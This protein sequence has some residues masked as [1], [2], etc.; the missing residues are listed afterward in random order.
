MSQTE[1]AVTPSSGGKRAYRKR[2][3]LSDAE[4]QR[5]SLARKRA[6]LK[7]VKIFI[8]PKYKSMLMQMCDEDGVTQAEVLSVLIEREAQRRYIQ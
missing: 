1:N 5:L 4:K 8:E 3:P 6:S 7:E 2:N